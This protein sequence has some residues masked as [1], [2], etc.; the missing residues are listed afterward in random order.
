MFTT[1]NGTRAMHRSRLADRVLVGA[2]VNLSAVVRDVSNDSQPVHIVCAGTRGKISAED[3]LC[4]GVL[5]QRLQNKNAVPPWRLN[6]EA[7]LAVKFAA[8]RAT[9]QRSLLESVRNSHGGRNLTALGFDA[10]VECAVEMDRF[11]LAPEFDASTG[12]IQ[13][14]LES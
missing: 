5:V 12:Q 6:D 8:N 13:T 9:D 7:Q 4:A 1:T 10:D 2:F 14:A 3:C 11:D